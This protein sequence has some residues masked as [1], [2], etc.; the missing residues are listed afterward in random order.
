MKAAPVRAELLRKARRARAG[1]CF[2]CG[3]TWERA[4]EPTCWWAP[5]T[6]H[7]VCSAHSQ[8]KIEEA[9]RALRAADR[10]ARRA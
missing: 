3:C 4:C 10:G 7:R 5:R 9:E 8:Q 1:R 2:L 6:G